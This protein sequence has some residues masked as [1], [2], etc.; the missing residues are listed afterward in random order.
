VVYDARG[1][2]LRNITA[3]YAA[4]PRETRL[5]RRVDAASPLTSYLLGPEWYA[6]DGDH[7]WIP[8]RAT[9]RL[10]GPSAAGQKLN[11]TGQCPNEQ[12][13]NGPLPIAVTVDGSAMPPAMIHDP[14]FELAFALPDSLV[15]K[16][17]IHV[18][19]EVGRTFRPASDPRD[20]GLV[21]GVFEVK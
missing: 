17:E 6:S 4:M 18:S 13:R 16:P 5:P 8:R 2:R 1:S 14:V 3:I 7:R 15:G 21:F 12:L 20:L 19:V 11:L 9:L 10:G